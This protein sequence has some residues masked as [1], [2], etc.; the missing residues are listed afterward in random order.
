MCGDRKGYGCVV[1]EVIDAPCA[2][3]LARIR[4]DKRRW[5]CREEACQ[6]MTF[7]EYDERV[8]APRAR[9][10][11]RAIRWAIGQLRFEGATI[12][13]L[14][15]SPAPNYEEPIWCRKQLVMV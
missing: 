5:H 13:G 12:V 6:M 3:I 10:S 7:L 4:C 14:D 15:V 2:G 1:V 11:A 8:C 9:L